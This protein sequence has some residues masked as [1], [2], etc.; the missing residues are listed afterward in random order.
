MPC[1]LF[2]CVI[3]KYWKLSFRIISKSLNI[4]QVCIQCKC[5]VQVC[6]Q[7]KCTIQ[8]FVC[9]QCKMY[10]TSVYA[11][12]MYYCMSVYATWMHCTSLHTMYGC[13]HNVSCHYTKNC[14][15]LLYW[16]VSLWHIIK[17]WLFFWKNVT[18]CLWLCLKGECE[19][20][21][22]RSCENGVRLIDSR[23][24]LLVEEVQS[25]LKCWIKRRLATS[26][27]LLEEVPS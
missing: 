12:K 1:S 24:R 27:K 18:H 17:Y 16:M 6:M 2:L 26:S 10:W 21:G 3:S 4:V 20:T 14:N 9:M 8:D 11:M 22:C 19:K 23:K 15:N 7:W 25:P 13:V 5:T